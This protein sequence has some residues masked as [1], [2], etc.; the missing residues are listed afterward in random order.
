MAKFWAR[1][2]TAVMALQ[3][4][5]AMDRIL[6]RLQRS[7]S[8]AIGMPSVAKKSANAGPPKSP[9]CVSE[10]YSSSLMG[11]SRIARIDRSTKLTT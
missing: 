2:Q 6:A 1:P 4:I 3:M 9:S 10:S 11:S 8:A 5:M 7:A